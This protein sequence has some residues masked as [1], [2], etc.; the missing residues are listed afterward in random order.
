MSDGQ[1]LQRQ[2]RAKAP[3][4]SPLGMDHT[5][6]VLSA[7]TVASLVLPEDSASVRWVIGWWLFVFVK[8]EGT[9]VGGEAATVYAATMLGSLVLVQFT[10]SITGFAVKNEALH[11]VA[12]THEEVAAWGKSAESVTICQCLGVCVGEGRGRPFNSW[13]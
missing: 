7:L 4:R 13:S 10:D 5:L 11:V 3:K 1:Q 8:Q 2:S 9:P 6:T 12:H